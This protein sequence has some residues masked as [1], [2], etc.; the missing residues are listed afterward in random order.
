MKA[1]SIRTQVFILMFFLIFIC[2]PSLI[3]ETKGLLDW[4]DIY[5][6]ENNAEVTNNQT[7]DIILHI[8]SLKSYTLTTE[9]QR[10]FKAAEFMSNLLPKLNSAYLISSKSDAV[11]SNSIKN[12]DK[13]Y[14]D[15]GAFYSNYYPEFSEQ[16]LQIINSSK[17]MDLIFPNIMQKSI[18][19][20]YFGF[21]V[22]EIFYIY[23]GVIMPSGY[24][25]IIRE[26]YY[27]AI[28]NR[29][30]IILTE[31]Y[32]DAVEKVYVIT[33]SKTV[34]LDGKVY[35]VAAV[36][37]TCDYMKQLVSVKRESI[38]LIIILSTIK[39]AM[40]VN[41]WNYSLETRLF[42]EDITGFSESLWEKITGP[43]FYDNTSFEFST[44]GQ[45]NYFCFRRMINPYNESTH[46]LIIC[47]NESNLQDSSDK[48]GI[49]FYK[50]YTKIFFGVIITLFSAL[51]LNV[52]VNFYFSS[53]LVKSLIDIHDYVKRLITASLAKSF[54]YQML[55]FPAKHDFISIDSIFECFNARIDNIQRL[56]RIFSNYNWHSSRPSEDLLYKN[57][58][59]SFFP[60]NMIG[61]KVK[62]IRYLFVQ[63]T[64]I[65]KRKNRRQIAYTV[66]GLANYD[67][68]TLNNEASKLEK[69][70]LINKVIEV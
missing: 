63:C 67:L 2:F 15:F 62:K 33:A 28:V 31:P 59:T 13:V 6:A 11:F 7:K 3:V 30:K 51:F 55:K 69:L 53:K 54:D 18:M 70:V 27:Q 49:S 36:D 45:I 21:E 61:F 16:G 38:E 4:I 35:A 58:S 44:I 10:Y 46:I 26:W 9:L 65:T 43:R 32:V 5:L 50:S 39:G 19:W 56:E 57:W 42:Q 14:E 52:I 47:T 66:N 12:T 60:M 20:M 8:L 17:A 41:P 34:E 25:H 37:I 68:P 1:L 64:N 48:K 24:T 40:I 22:D 23:P 29:G